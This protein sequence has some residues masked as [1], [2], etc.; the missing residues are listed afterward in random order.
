MACSVYCFEQASQQR[1]ESFDWVYN[2][3]SKERR[4]GGA[5]G[6]PCTVHMAPRQEMGVDGQ[7]RMGRIEPDDALSPAKEE[8]NF[9]LRS[10]QPIP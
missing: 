7:A 10:P 1:G 6:W 8:P 9:M 5:S 2:V 4:A 3:A